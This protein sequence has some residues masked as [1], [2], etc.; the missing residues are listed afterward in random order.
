VLTGVVFSILF[1]ALPGAAVLF[2]VG[3][4]DLNLDLSWFPSALTI[5]TVGGFLGALFTVILF[6][7]D[8]YIPYVEQ[9]QEFEEDSED[10][11]FH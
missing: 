8:R 2:L 7:K 5:L 6:V 4:L 10:D 3:V 11:R 1:V 9:L